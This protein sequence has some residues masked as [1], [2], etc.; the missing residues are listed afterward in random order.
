MG[1]FNFIKSQLSTVIEWENQNTNLLWYKFPSK[2]NEIKNASKLI[3]APGQGCVLVYEGK[4]AD[5]I[6]QDGIYNLETDNH[7]FITTLLKIRQSF[8]SEHKLMVYFYRKADTFNQAWG[9]SMPIKY[10]DAVYQF[11]IEMG[12]NGNFS[13][14]IK[15]IKFFFENV[16]GSKDN[17]S[18][19]EA[20]EI[21]ANRIPQEIASNLAT[22]KF[23]YQ[24]IDAQ[25]NS[26]SVDIKEKLNFDFET[27][28]LQ[29][30]DFKIIG[31]RFD[32]ATQKRISKISDITADAMA[33]EKGG[34]NYIELEKLRALRDA[35][36][37]EGGL[38]GSGLQFGV[39]MELG[40][41]LNNKTEETLNK[42][43]GDI[44][45]KL[46]KLKL[47]FN[48]GII[49]EADFEMKKKEFLSNF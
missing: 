3:V 34:L 48:E 22:K 49:S 21:I 45:E 11:P 29:L 25:L 46:Q 9:T 5:V 23:S 7:P 20:K 26:I 28:G 17:Y 12:A 36:Q 6:Q 4:I 47:L 42:T 15:D 13:Y 33:A 10:V 32:D 16:I 39:G 43:E 41:T 27:L 19:Y 31:T 8:E 1:I 18:I 24:E 35:A 38:A 30:T 14:S 37:N 40:K 2:K 44:V